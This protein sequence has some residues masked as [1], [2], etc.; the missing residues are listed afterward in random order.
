MIPVGIVL[1]KR[2]LTLAGQKTDFLE[3]LM[4]QNTKIV[5]I[6]KLIQVF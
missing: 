6:V 1:K 3:T 5:T 2:M 4:N